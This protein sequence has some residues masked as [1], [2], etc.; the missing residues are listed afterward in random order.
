MAGASGQER[1]LGKR[2]PPPLSLPQASGE[3]RQGGKSRL[4]PLSTPLLRKLDSGKGAGRKSGRQASLSPPGQGNQCRV[5]GTCGSGEPAGVKPG[6]QMTS[7][8]RNRELWS[9]WDWNSSPRTG[10]VPGGFGLAAQQEGFSV[11]VPSALDGRH[12]PNSQRL[13]TKFPRVQNPQQQ[14]LHG[15]QCARP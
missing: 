5:L 2:L 12:D 4:C 13:A 6:F 14:G 8:L 7:R 3:R 1:S 11:V 9:C 10:P 15:L